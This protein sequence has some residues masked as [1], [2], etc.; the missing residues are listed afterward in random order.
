MHCN[1]ISIKEHED[2][3]AALFEEYDILSINETN[4]KLQQLFSC[5][6]YNIFR[7]NK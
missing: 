2:K 1:A 4:L 3:I 5:P 6:E 7:N